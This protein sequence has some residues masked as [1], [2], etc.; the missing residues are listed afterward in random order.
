MQ[1]AADTLRTI[2]S[3]PKAS[4]QGKLR[5]ADLLLSYGVGEMSLDVETRLSAL[6]SRR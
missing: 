6:E 1:A 5:A 4:E 3:D 2:L